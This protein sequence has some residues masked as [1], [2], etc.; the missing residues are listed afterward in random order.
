MAQQQPKAVYDYD[1]AGNRI[2]RTVLNLK[3]A[4]S[5]TPDQERED[6]ISDLLKSYS[7]SKF[8]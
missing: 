4:R 6:K 5:A 2:A 8:Y 7:L 1:M 3:S